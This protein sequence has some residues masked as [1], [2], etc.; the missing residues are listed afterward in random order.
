MCSIVR[1][2]GGLA[3]FVNS[4]L[5]VRFFCCLLDL[6][7]LKMAESKP[8]PT[9]KT[10]MGELQGQV[11]S[12]SQV[13]SQLVVEMRQMAVEFQEL[14]AIKGDLAAIK[15]DLAA[16]KGN[17]AATKS[18]L[19]ACREKVDP[20]S[21][22][23]EKGKSRSETPTRNLFLGETE[24]SSES[25]SP[26]RNPGKRKS[27]TTQAPRVPGTED[28][29][30]DLARL[31][32]LMQRPREA[33]KPEVYSLELGH[34][35]RAFLRSFKSYCTS[36]YGHATKEDWT[37]ELGRLLTGELKSVFDVV[38]GFERPY[39][40]MAHELKEYVSRQGTRIAAERHHGF[41]EALQLP[42]ESLRMYALRL[43]R[44]FVKA[45]PKRPRV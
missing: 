25:S 32:R 45:F 30:D 4:P 19:A 36:R 16:N 14:K 38:G 43:E 8:E 27:R 17:L 20:A 10:E 26:I 33:P 22:A 37:P 18:D 2:F 5:G 9:P 15:G 11:A 21:G 7:L 28:E 44:L 1:S 39:P 35:L 34:S 40:A 13:V 31:A 3:L 12:L 23:K 29:K 24:S 42:E 41:Q 6:F